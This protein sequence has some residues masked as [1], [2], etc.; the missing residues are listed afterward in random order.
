VA[1]EVPLTLRRFP[2]QAIVPKVA[3]LDAGITWLL[4]L[5]GRGGGLQEPL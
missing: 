1:A 3:L 4:A 2:V 5:I